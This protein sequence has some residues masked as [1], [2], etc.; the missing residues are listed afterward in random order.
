MIKSIPSTINGV[1]V[2]LNASHSQTLMVLFDLPGH[3]T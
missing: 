3:I 2:L 1:L